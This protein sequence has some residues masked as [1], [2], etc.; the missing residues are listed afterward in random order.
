LLLTALDQI[1][2]LVND[3]PTLAVMPPE[4]EATMVKLRARASGQ[5]VP[6]EAPKPAAV[7]AKLALVLEPS[8]TARAVMTSQLEG[9]GW[10]VKSTDDVAHAENTALE[11]QLIVLPLEP[12]GVDGLA[13]AKSWLEAGLKTRIVVTALE[14]SDAEQAIAQQMKVV[15]QVKPSLKDPSWLEGID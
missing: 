14:F 12:H 10:Q 11:A 2:N 8:A 1:R 9:A 3:D 6:V 4:V 13:L 15:T 7:Q 5:S